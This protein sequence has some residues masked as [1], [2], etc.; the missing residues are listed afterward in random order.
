M[1]PSES[2]SGLFEFEV[3]AEPKQAPY[4]DPMRTIPLALAIA[5]PVTFPVW[6]KVDFRRD[7]Q[8]ILETRCVRCHGPDVAMKNLRLNRKDRAMSVIVPKKPED[9]RLYLAIQS[10]Y[11]PP[12]GKKLPDSEIETLRKWIEEGAR[13]PKNLE[14]TPK[15]PN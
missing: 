9:S 14:L 2:A 15:L 6:A 5:L 1:K 8:P 10:G 4:N 13:W 7:V 11:M 12:A 3:R